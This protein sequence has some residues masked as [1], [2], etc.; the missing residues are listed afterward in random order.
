MLHFCATLLVV[1]QPLVTRHRTGR[2]RWSDALWRSAF[3]RSAW[4]KCHSDTLERRA[5]SAG[6][7][8]SSWFLGWRTPLNRPDNVAVLPARSLLLQWDWTEKQF[9]VARGHTSGTPTWCVPLGAHWRG[10][11]GLACQL[12]FVPA[13]AKWEQNQVRY[14]FQRTKVTCTNAR[15]HA[16]RSVPDSF[17]HQWAL[18]VSYMG[19]FVCCLRWR[20]SHHG[21][22][23]ER[24]L[25]EIVVCSSG[26]FFQLW[27]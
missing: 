7:C 2:A 14:A 16:A 3:W 26:T 4:G 15:A 9:Y 19:T 18:N 20:Y 22:V 13:P 12:L 8:V 23:F 17:K 27:C 6:P 10:K 25:P 5:V 1:Q 21:P 11:V 24:W